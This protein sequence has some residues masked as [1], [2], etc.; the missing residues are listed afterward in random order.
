MKPLS[1]LKAYQ[2][3]PR[4]N[5]SAILAVKKSI[6]EFGWN[7][8]IVAEKDGTIVVG[9][10]RFEAAKL[11]A[12]EGHDKEGVPVVVA[13]KLTPEQLAAYRLV[14]NKVHELAEW[15]QDKLML[16]IAQLM[17]ANFDLSGYGF[18]KE[19]LGLIETSAKQDFRYL[20]DF[21]VL[22]APK[23]QW[24][25][26]KAHEDVAAEM[27]STLRKQ[28]KDTGVVIHYSGEAPPAP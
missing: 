28:Y 22:P 8:P 20:E 13:D 10:T 11:R 5:K 15:D 16:E 2:N 27:V 26:I 18:S 14:D 23:P 21:E 25:L 4:D 3:N 19:D 12:K 6:D 1:W 24:V 9:H 17:E 7:Q